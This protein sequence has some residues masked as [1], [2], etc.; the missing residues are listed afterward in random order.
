[1][2]EIFKKYSGILLF[3]LVIVG[4]VLFVNTNSNDKN[5]QSNIITYAIK[6]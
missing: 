4:I 2:L 3:Y 6:E 5:N 1:M